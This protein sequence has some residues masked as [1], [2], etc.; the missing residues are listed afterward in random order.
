MPKLI[1]LLKSLE[2]FC[3]SI[4]SDNVDS[5]NDSSF[6]IYFGVFNLVEMFGILPVTSTTKYL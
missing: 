6:L 5:V 4:T 1:Y 3:S 2:S